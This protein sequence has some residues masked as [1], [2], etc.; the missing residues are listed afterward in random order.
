TRN[1]KRSANNKILAIAK[2]AKR[3]R[4]K[5]E[6]IDPSININYLQD[7]PNNANKQGCKK[8]HETVVSSSLQ[9]IDKLLNDDNN[10]QDD[11]EE[12]ISIGELSQ[13]SLTSLRQ[14]LPVL[15]SRIVS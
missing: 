2:P 10:L 1:S 12:V 5:K 14:L 6:N 15:E 8:K 3:G 11:D 7:K 13:S 9:I 4:K